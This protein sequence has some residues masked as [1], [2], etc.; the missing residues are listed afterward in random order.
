MREGKLFLSSTAHEAFYA[1]IASKAAAS[2]SSGARMPVIGRKRPLRVLK[3]RLRL[4]L[5][6]LASSEDFLRAITPD[7]VPPLLRRLAAIKGAPAEYFADGSLFE[8]AFGRLPPSGAARS[9]WERPLTWEASQPHR[10]DREINTGN[11]L[12]QSPGRELTSWQASVVTYCWAEHA[13]RQIG[14]EPREAYCLYR[15]WL[16]DQVKVTQIDPAL[17]A[18]AARLLGWFC[19]HPD[20]LL[21]ECAARVPPEPRENLGGECHFV[22]ARLIAKPLKVHPTQPPTRGREGRPIDWIP[23]DKREP[24]AAMEFDRDAVN[25]VRL[26]E[27]IEALAAAFGDGD[28]RS[29][30]VGFDDD[31]VSL[32]VTH[33]LWK[34][35][36][37]NA[38]PSILSGLGKGGLS[39]RPRLRTRPLAP[40]FALAYISHGNMGAEL[41]AKGFYATLFG[42]TMRKGSNSGDPHLL[43]LL[44]GVLNRY[45]DVVARMRKAY[46]DEGGLIA[47]GF[48][49]RKP[50]FFSGILSLRT[51]HDQ[52][53]LMAAGCARL[54]NGPLSRKL[55]GD[56][57]ESGV[58]LGNLSRGEVY[59]LY[60]SATPEVFEQLVNADA[61]ANR[62]HRTLPA[63]TVRELRAPEAMKREPRCEMRLRL[64]ARDRE[65]ADPPP[66]TPQFVR[67]LYEAER[68]SREPPDRRGDPDAAESEICLDWC[69]IWESD[70]VKGLPAKW[71]FPVTIDSLSPQRPDDLFFSAHRD[72]EACISIH[73][74]TRVRVLAK[75]ETDEDMNSSEI[76]TEPVGRSPRWWWVETCLDD[77]SDGRSKS[78]SEAW[79]ACDVN[80]LLDDIRE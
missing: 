27:S 2:G 55:D 9:S 53:A 5:R 37:L 50:G 34:F 59:G 72:A 19:G 25:P 3:K 79:R 24:H 40:F 23:F 10:V 31:R 22:R 38:V 35:V 41:A 46:R 43:A 14:I 12:P 56:C 6:K 29:F 13:A 16:I 47:G 51:L 65:E 11:A 45:D 63:P 73:P 78:F 60:S 8:R 71:A 62:E 80:L 20:E 28:A 15:D 76:R 49:H 77:R 58:S 36:T 74:V 30:K 48:D 18:S 42:G 1:V 32:H 26:H 64:E 67:A 52:R 33:R 54:P 39:C 70:I 61:N 7:D 75:F 17:R 44:P 21:D 69:A 66:P 57:S 68:M 4:I